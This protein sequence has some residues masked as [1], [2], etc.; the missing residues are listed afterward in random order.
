M[1]VNFQDYSI[2]TLDTYKFQNKMVLILKKKK[3]ISNI[4]F[5]YMSYNCKLQDICIEFVDLVY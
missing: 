2:L 4:I 1:T 3:R 5:L